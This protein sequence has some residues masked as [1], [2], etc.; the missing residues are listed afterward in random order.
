MSLENKVCVITGGGSGIGEA[1]AKLM[2]AE[3]AKVAVVGRTFSK[4]ERVKDEIESHGDTA[5]AFPLNVSDVNEVKETVTLITKRFGPIDVL[6][7]S[8]GHSSL[9]RKLL[10]TTPEEICQVIHSNLTGTIYC[11]QAVVPGMLKVKRGT[12]INLS[13]L[14]GLAPSLLAGMAYSSAKA[15]VINFTEFLNSEYR[16]TGIRASVV[17]PGEVATPIMD[18][19]PVVPDSAARSTMVTAEHTA[20]AIALIA[21]LP[22]QTTIPKLVIRPTYLRDYSAELGTM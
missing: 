14:A 19:R 18:R 1:T 16:N 10:T 17:I 21:R 4:L 5:I 12:I 22:Q 13:S 8:A 20:E 2:A 3:G 9:H 15:A 7:N 6:V 11:C